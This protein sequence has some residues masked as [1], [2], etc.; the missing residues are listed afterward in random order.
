MWRDD[1]HH[2]YVVGFTAAALDVL[3][4]YVVTQAVFGSEADAIRLQWRID[5]G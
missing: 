3:V 2:A 5:H 4:Q 1:H